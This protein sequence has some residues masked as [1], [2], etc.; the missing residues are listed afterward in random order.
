M[1]RRTQR[2]PHKSK[3]G[4]SG[5][6]F[7]SNPETRLERSR[8]TSKLH[9]YLRIALAFVVTVLVCCLLDLK[10]FDYLEKFANGL[11]LEVYAAYDR[12]AV[13][14]ACDRIRL[15]TIS[16]RSYSSGALPRGTR[17]PRTYHAKLIRQLTRLGARV[18]AFDLYFT[19]ET[20]HDRE[21][22]EAVRSSGRVVWACRVEDADEFTPRRVVPTIRAL[23]D[24]SPHV[25]HCAVPQ[26]ADLPV[27]DRIRAIEPDGHRLLPALSLEAVLMARG[28][29]KAPIR[30]I[31]DG[32][33]IGSLKIPVDRDGYFRISYM[34]SPEEAFGH[35]PFENVY[36]GKLDEF[37]RKT[38]FFKDKIVLVGDTTTANSDFFYTPVG[39]MSGVEVHANA[40]A[41]LLQG[42]FISEASRGTNEFVI[43]LLAGCVFLL[44]GVRSLFRVALS[45]CILLAG[46]FVAN[47]WVFCAHGFL[48]HMVAPMAA[49]L[50]GTVIMLGERALTEELEKTRMRWLLRRYVSPEIAEYI[51]ANP[52]ACVLGGKRVTASVLFADI[53]GFTT[54]AEKLPP[55][56]V[57]DRLN[58]FFGAMT[59]VAFAHDATVDKFV[60]DAIM[61]LFGIPVPCPDHARRAVATAIDMQAALVELQKKWR[62]DGLPALD[63]GIGINTGE[64]VAGSIGSDQRL[65]FTV[66]GDAVNTASRV[67]DLN[68]E[69]GTSILAAAATYEAVKDEVSVRGP[70]SGTVKGKEFTAYEIIGWRDGSLSDESSKDG[71]K[72]WV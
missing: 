28:L 25:G 20:T 17:L 46:Y 52:D 41:T 45:V 34:G 19:D 48:L 54:V 32:W 44:A 14:K 57:V 10:A 33:R 43:C 51:I 56:A 50:M 15:V 72:L 7:H 67:Q 65:E 63:I 58:E 13:Q 35:F 36:D 4:V 21:L 39:D 3:L 31:R 47:I 6:P 18:I 71:E 59:A 23:L 8:P 30:R 1:T 61:V 27:V 12:P 66:I 68:R 40:I 69:L 37:F 2:Q 70:L 26:D 22:A 38:G 53:R 64:M 49:I 9:R 42:R 60:G 5:F 62:A 29:D 16:D 55:E 11:R 24:A